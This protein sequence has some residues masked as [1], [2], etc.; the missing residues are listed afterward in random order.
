MST[1]G[2]TAVREQDSNSV[3]VHR[4]PMSLCSLP[5]QMVDV[6]SI[7]RGVVLTENPLIRYNRNHGN[8]VS[9]GK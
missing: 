7:A 3:Y 1:S 8:I 4:K 9:F 6:N 2:R 5:Y